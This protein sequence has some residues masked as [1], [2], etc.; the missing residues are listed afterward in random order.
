MGVHI[1]RDENEKVARRKKIR[2]ILRIATRHAHADLVLSAFGC[3]A[4]RNR[5]H[6]VARLFRETLG[7]DEFGGVFRQEVF[8]IF[9]DHNAGGRHSP[10]GNY[11]PFAREFDGSKP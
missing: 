3:G 1:R 7:E 10:D 4:F 6:H 5:P 9:D 8:A 11:A 2:A